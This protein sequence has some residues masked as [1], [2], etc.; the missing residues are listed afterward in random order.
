[1]SLT[2]NFLE[3]LN[4]DALEFYK[5]D[6]FEYVE[7]LIDDYISKGMK[8][9]KKLDELIFSNSDSIYVYS[10]LLEKGYIFKNMITVLS[11]LQDLSKELPAELPAELLKLSFG[12]ERL[13]NMLKQP[14]IK[15][16][17]DMEEIIITDSDIKQFNKI[18][19]IGHIIKLILQNKIKECKYIKWPRITIKLEKYINH[20]NETN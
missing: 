1:M 18:Q 17:I 9:T 6:Q 14:E 19:D 4:K 16:Y 10:Y 2:K 12:N 13:V 7:N 15:K 8:L 3:T 11:I 20:Y 5:Y